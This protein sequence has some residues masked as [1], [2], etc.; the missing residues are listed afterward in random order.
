MLILPQHIAHIFTVLPK[1]TSTPSGV[2]S[3]VWLAGDGPRRGEEGVDAVHPKTA[4]QLKTAFRRKTSLR[5]T[6]QLQ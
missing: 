3:G 6:L 1:L 5:R 4:F 2:G